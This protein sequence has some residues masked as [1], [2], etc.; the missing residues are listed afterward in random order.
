[1]KHTLVFNIFVASGLLSLFVGAVA[2]GEACDPLAEAFRKA[3]RQDRMGERVSVMGMVN[4]NRRIGNVRCESSKAANG[5]DSCH[6]AKGPDITSVLAKGRADMI[7]E[8]EKAGHKC[9]LIGTEKIDG[10]NAHKYGVSSEEA[11]DFSEL[12]WVS[13]QTGLPIAWGDDLA[14]PGGIKIVYG[15]GVKDCNCKKK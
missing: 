3:D 15:D 10:E 13:I 2:W 9:R 6:D 11:P 8:L 14:F 12:Y 7:L 4:N 5:V 1:V